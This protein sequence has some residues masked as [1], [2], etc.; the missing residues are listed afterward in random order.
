MLHRHASKLVAFPDGFLLHEATN[1]G[2]FLSYSKNVVWTSIGV[3]RRMQLVLEGCRR[4]NSLKQWSYPLGSRML[5]V[6]VWK[7]CWIRKLLHNVSP[8]YMYAVYLWKYSIASHS[9]F[10]RRNS[11][12]LE[13]WR[14]IS[15]KTL[16]YLFGAC[17][18]PFFCTNQSNNTARAHHRANNY[19]ANTARSS[20]RRW[21]FRSDCSIEF[22]S[23]HTRRLR[24]RK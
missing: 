1:R 6:N 2:F 21:W 8:Y 24:Q 12:D 20:G 11:Y 9:E 13:K 23:V 15:S 19:V 18:E 4:G 7:V 5:L 22:C 14:F 3:Q 16:G 17:A 10:M